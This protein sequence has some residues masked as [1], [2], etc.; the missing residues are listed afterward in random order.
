[1][2]DSGEQLVEIGDVTRRRRCRCARGAAPSCRTR[3]HGAQRP[4]DAA[5][6]DD[7]ERRA[8][9]VAAEVLRDAPAVPA[10]G[11]QVGFGVVREP[12]RGEDQRE[13]E[14]GGRLVEHARR[15]AHHD[16]V[17]G[18][19]RRRRRCRSRRRRWPRPSTSPRRPRRSRGVDLVGEHAHDR[20]DTRRVRDELV[21]GVTASRRRSG[22]RARGPRADRARRRGDGG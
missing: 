13:R 8:V 4:A 21:G 9:H 15:V 20:V 5:V 16:A 12:R 6:A 17:L 11:A 10:A 7:A 1:M 3:R 2:S 18:A 14:V 22:R 19:R